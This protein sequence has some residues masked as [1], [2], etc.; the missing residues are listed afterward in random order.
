M[1]TASA[2]SDAKPAMMA[3][4]GL[5][6]RMLRHQGAQKNMARR[7]KVALHGWRKNTQVLEEEERRKN[8][9]YKGSMRGLSACETFLGKHIKR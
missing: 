3:S 6:R 8:W 9:F 4:T 2:G 7:R 5:S 1:T